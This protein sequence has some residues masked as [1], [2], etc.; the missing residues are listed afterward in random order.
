MPQHPN[1]LLRVAVREVEAWLFAHKTAFAEFLGVSRDLIPD[2]V[3][4]VENP[5]EF[6]VTLASSLTA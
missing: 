4:Q 3:E 2:N 6:V 1:L 5:K